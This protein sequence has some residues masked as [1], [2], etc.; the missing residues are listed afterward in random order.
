MVESYNEL[1][2]KYGITKWINVDGL[3]S[4][5]LTRAILL[6]RRR[7]STVCRPPLTL[8]FLATD[9]VA[10]DHL[11]PDLIRTPRA[12][13]QRLSTAFTAEA[14]RTSPARPRAQFAPCARLGRDDQRRRPCI[15]TPFGVRRRRRPHGDSC[16]RP[17]RLLVRPPRPLA[18]PRPAGGCR[19]RP[20]RCRCRPLA[21]PRPLAHVRQHHVVGPHGGGRRLRALSV[22]RPCRRRAGTSAAPSWHTVS[23]S[24]GR[25]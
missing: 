14:R 24:T 18:N 6:R 3:R 20:G 10:T 25:G 11:P 19:T 12:H 15:V 13:T 17:R 7:R 4:M 23:V 2:S 22:R 8:Q 16:Q 9:A 21:R 5:S 1:P